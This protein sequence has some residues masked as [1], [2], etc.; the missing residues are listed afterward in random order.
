MLKGGPIQTA[1][2]IADQ[3]LGVDPAPV[4]DP[5]QFEIPHRT[6]LQSAAIRLDMVMCKAMWNSSVSDWKVS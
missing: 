3:L 2:L 4:R 1:L 5:S 6:T